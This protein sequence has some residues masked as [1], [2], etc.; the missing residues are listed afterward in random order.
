LGVRETA[1]ERRVLQEVRLHVDD[2]Q[3]TVSGAVDDYL[4]LGGVERGGLA[5]VKP[6]ASTGAEC[7]GPV[8]RRRFQCHCT[9]REPGRRQ[10]ELPT[11]LAMPS[12]IVVG[13][14]SGPTHR[15]GLQ[16]VERRRNVLTV[17]ARPQLDRQAGIVVV[18]VHGVPRPRRPHAAAPR[19]APRRS[20]RCTIDIAL[21]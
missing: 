20:H 2:R 15:F 13:A 7:L 18:F 11:G 5:D 1:A 4:R 8:P 9:R 3:R 21:T 16:L 12:G 19:L 10:Q 6:S 14:I 17:R